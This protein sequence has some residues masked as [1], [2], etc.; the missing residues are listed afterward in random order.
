[1]TLEE[2]SKLRLLAKVLLLEGINNKV[3]AGCN[4]NDLDENMNDIH[5]GKLRGSHK[6]KNE[7]F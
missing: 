2:L 7:E 5:N 3:M 6:S 4:S 1:M